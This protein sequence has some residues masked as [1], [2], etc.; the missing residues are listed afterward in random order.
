VKNRGGIVGYASGVYDPFHVGHLNILR[1]AKSRC[2]HLIAGVVS[3]EM[4]ELAR[5]RPA[6]VPR[7]ERLE[8]ARQDGDVAGAAL[9]RHLQRERLARNSQGRQAREGVR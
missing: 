2:D 4:A 6:V 7:C 1:E 9:R 5:G 8:I 3:D